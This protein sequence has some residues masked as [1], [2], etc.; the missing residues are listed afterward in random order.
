MKFPYAA[1]DVDATLAAPSREVACRP[2]VPIRVS[3]A[4]TALDLYGLVDTGADECFVS[5]DVAFE[6]GLLP[7]VVGVIQG[8]WGEPILG[9]AGFLEHFDATF[10]YAD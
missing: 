9:H 6:L 10:S 3:N 7:L 4:G 5:S 2:V 1:Y 8:T